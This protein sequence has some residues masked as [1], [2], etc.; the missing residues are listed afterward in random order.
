MSSQKTQKMVSRR[1]FIEVSGKAGTAAVVSTMAFP[2]LSL[3]S[4]PM[5]D[6]VR[7]AHKV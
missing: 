5:A 6:P 2:T 4:D 3:G 7:I 1:E